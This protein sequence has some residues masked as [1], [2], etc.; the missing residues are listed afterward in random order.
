MIEDEYIRLIFGLKLKQI[1]T[2][3]KLSLFGLAKLTGLSKSYLNEIEKEAAKLKDIGEIRKWCIEALLEDDTEAQDALQAVAENKL[4]MMKKKKM[5]T[6]EK[7]GRQQQVQRRRPQLPSL[8][9]HHCHRN[10]TTNQT[11]QNAKRKRTT[12][13]V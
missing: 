6:M 1:R 4:G 11:Q 3:K 2:E 13:M 9:Q 8:C 7:N 5:P 10:T 12:M